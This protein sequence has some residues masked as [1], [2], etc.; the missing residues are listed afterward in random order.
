MTDTPR[1]NGEES[2]NVV[3]V[4]LHQP[5]V[6]TSHADL[7]AKVGGSLAGLL[8][9]ITFKR[10]GYN[11]H[12]LEQKTSSTRAS[13]AVGIGLGPRGLDFSRC[14]IGARSLMPLHA[15]ASRC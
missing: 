8:Y 5:V 4:S 10:L 13:Q 15:L 3:I 7:I 12:L 9:G 6:I 11:V 14:M 1:V 2:L